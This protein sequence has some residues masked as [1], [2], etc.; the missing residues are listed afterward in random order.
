MVTTKFIEDT[1]LIEKGKKR[2]LGDL[3]YKSGP[4]K[5]LFDNILNIYLVLYI[6]AISYEF[7]HW[8]KTGSVPM[9][10]VSLLG[11]M[12]ASLTY[13]LH[14]Y[15]QADAKQIRNTM[16]SLTVLLIIILLK[17]ILRMKSRSRAI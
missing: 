4:M 14:A 11:G 9:T 16:I 17:T 13:G 1:F 10:Y 7:R 15:Q 5:T 2:K 6:F 12:F 3:K 8:I